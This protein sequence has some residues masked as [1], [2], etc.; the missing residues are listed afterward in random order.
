MTTRD[1][2]ATDCL[3][4][5][6]I[7]TSRKTIV[8]PVLRFASPPPNVISRNQAIDAGDRL[9]D[10]RPCFNCCL[11]QVSNNAADRQLQKVFI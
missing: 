2:A 4:V 10:E 7:K 9:K 1:L 8:A 5:I 11:K 6:N 3:N